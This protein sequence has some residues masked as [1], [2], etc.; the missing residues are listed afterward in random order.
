MLERRA[1]IYDEILGYEA[2][3]LL[4][5]SSVALSAKCKRQRLNSRRPENNLEQPVG[6]RPRT[7]APAGT[8]LLAGCTLS[9]RHPCLLH[10]HRTGDAVNKYSKP[11]TTDP[12]PTGP[13]TSSRHAMPAVSNAATGGCQTRID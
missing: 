3:G 4:M 8:A 12:A 2:T 6:N 13:I 5:L 7:A 11:Q 1:L 10:G 9:P